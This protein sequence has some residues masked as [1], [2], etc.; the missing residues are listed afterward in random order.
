MF[1]YHE[2]VTTSNNPNPYLA[3]CEIFGISKTE[4]A[5]CAGVTVSTVNKWISSFSNLPNGLAL[6][7]LK[8]AFGISIDCL[9]LGRVVLLEDEDRIPW[10]MPYIPSAIVIKS[11]LE[12]KCISISE[13]SK[14]IGISVDDIIGYEI[15][16]PIPY[17]VAET[18]SEKCGIP[19]ELLY[20]YKEYDDRTPKSRKKAL[21]AL[22]M[23]YSSD[24][25]II[26]DLLNDMLTEKDD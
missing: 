19:M 26:T 17:F 22:A 5:K 16:S 21:I 9:L 13:F 14:M 2:P 3:I 24:A 6:A 4:L 8:Q 12:M 20:G 11:Y 10:H 25:K 23:Q 1:R 18:I 7:L 15:G